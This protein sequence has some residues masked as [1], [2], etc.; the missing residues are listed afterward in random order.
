[1]G[2]AFSILAAC[3]VVPCVGCFTGIAA[4]VLLILTLVK[5]SAYKSLILHGGG[6]AFPL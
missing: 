4:L 2:L 3:S 5:F 1:M 6:G